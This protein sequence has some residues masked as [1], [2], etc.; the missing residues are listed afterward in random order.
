[1]STNSELLTWK[2]VK[3][4]LNDLYTALSESL[5]L[6]HVTRA[7]LADTTLLRYHF[8]RDAYKYI[9]EIVAGE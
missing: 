3:L 4:Y 1:M 6:H 9:I 7:R 2:W 8:T 5:L